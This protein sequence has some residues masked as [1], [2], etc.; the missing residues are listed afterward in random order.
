[1]KKILLLSAATPNFSK[2]WREWG[3]SPWVPAEGEDYTELTEES[4]E[5][6]LREYHQMGVSHVFTFDFA[7]AV[8]RCCICL[9]LCYVSW[10]VDCPHSA[11][12]SR[13]A[14]SEYCYIFAFDY[15]QYLILQG[16]GIRNSFYLPLYG[17]GWVRT[18]SGNGAG[19]KP[20]IYGGCV[21]CRKSLQ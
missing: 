7:P 16:R 14:R 19:G 10:V 3:Y 5:R 6:R 17:C 20:K 15:Q 12:W 11:L 1:M 13:Y 2:V 18:D 9:R 21:L 8:A 4:L